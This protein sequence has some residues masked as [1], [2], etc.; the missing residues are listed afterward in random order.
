MSLSHKKTLNTPSTIPF[1]LNRPKDGF[2]KK[3]D[4]IGLRVKQTSS[5]RKR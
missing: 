4:D 3:Y 1:P 2:G 5:S